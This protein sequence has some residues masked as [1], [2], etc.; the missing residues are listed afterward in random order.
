MR[1]TPTSAEDIYNK[2]KQPGRRPGSH[3]TSS[4]KARAARGKSKQPCVI[5]TNAGI[6]IDAEEDKAAAELLTS[7]T[8][9]QDDG[10]VS[11][12]REGFY[13]KT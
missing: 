8:K 4:G 7:P 9:N 1:D 12:E 13:P 3:T 11:A 6:M 10:D 2:P 5:P